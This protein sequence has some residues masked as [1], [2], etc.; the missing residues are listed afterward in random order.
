MP[1]NQWETLLEAGNI[2]L[3]SSKGLEISSEA[4]SWPEE[5]VGST[6]LGQ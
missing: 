4:Y 2:L 3:T 5:T 6:R 1:Q